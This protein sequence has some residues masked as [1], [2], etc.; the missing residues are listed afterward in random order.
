MMP[1]Y[2]VL[3]ETTFKLYSTFEIEAEDGFKAED[4]AYDY[5]NKL[6]PSG[7]EIFVNRAVAVEKEGK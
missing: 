3:V 2:K 7:A 1:S 5:A 6:K 4:I